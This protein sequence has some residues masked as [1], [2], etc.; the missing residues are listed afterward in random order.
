MSTDFDIKVSQ[1]G[2]VGKV[3]VEALD[4][5]SGFMNFLNVRGEVIG[6]DMNPIGVR[7]TQVGPGVYQGE[8]P[9]RDP[10]NYITLLN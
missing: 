7:L 5:D 10:G 1:D 6:P 2:N 9:V 3:T 8:F 4:K